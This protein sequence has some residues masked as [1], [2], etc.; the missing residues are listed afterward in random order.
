[1]TNNFYK[2][3]CSCGS[4]QSIEASQAGSEIKCPDCGTVRIVPSMLKIKQLEKV[5]DSRNQ[6]R[7]ETGALRRG[8]F[9]FGL[10]LLFPAIIAL[11]YRVNQYPM[12]RDVSKKPVY[13]AYGESML[14]QNSTPIPQ[15]EHVIL[16]TED[17]HIDMMLPFDLYRYFE[18]LKLGANFSYNFQMNYQ[19]LKYVYYTHIAISAL[20]V[21]LFVSCI[22]ASFF[23]PKRGVVIDG[24][25]GSDWERKK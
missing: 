2:F 1:M 12:P 8:F 10:I 11:I 14:Y 19:E 13:F 4:V 16:W 23:M 6:R 15:Y 5:I 22:T 18:V 17:E 7:E 24:W 21:V 3:P 9:W 20:L 25:T